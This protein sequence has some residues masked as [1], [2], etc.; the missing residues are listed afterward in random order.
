[1]R[2]IS[3]LLV[4]LSALYVSHTF[5][6]APLQSCD[7]TYKIGVCEP[8]FAKGQGPVIL[9]DEAHFN[10]HT[11][12]GRFCKFAEL[13]EKDGFVVRSNTEPFSAN[14]LSAGTVL[15]IANALHESNAGRAQDGA[16]DLPTPSAFS[17]SEISELVAW[18]EAG[19]NL[20]LIADHMPFPG[21][22]KK[23]AA[24][25]GASFTNTYVWQNAQQDR[26]ITFRSSDQTVRD[27]KVPGLDRIDSVTTFMGQAFTT[28]NRL[29]PLFVFAADAVAKKAIG[30]NKFGDNAFYSV[31]GQLQAAIGQHGKG[32]VAIFG[33]AAMFTA[34]YNR[35]LDIVMGFGHPRASQNQ[36]FILNLLR[37]LSQ[38]S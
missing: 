10:Y 38:K 20:L 19:G 9:I 27:H 28:D 6:Q 34:Q 13:L 18:V 35:R 7:K 11:R 17:H 2:S 1:M 22:A 5:A 29:D 32:R 14:E 4:V 8:R 24:E 30:W 33:E 3:C 21:A 23:L 12:E 31:A 25:F 15:V 37:W 26:L 16:W 36:A